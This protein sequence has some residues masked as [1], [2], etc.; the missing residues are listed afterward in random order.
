MSFSDWNRSLTKK[1]DDYEFG[2]MCP[3]SKI[4][5]MVLYLYSMELGSP[6]LYQEV[7]RVCREMDF[8]YLYELGPFIQALSYVTYYGEE[9]RIKGDKVTFGKRIKGNIFN[10]MGGSFLVFR[11]A[12][13]KSEWIE[14]Y[15]SNAGKDNVYL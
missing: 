13:M 9:N 1:I 14:G 11:G 12:A 4:T 2:V 15:I 8:T 3:Y 7:N 6:P 5:C 10:N